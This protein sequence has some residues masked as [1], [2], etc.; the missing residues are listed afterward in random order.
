[1]SV[2]LSG[3]TFEVKT[4]KLSLSEISFQI[5]GCVFLHNI[6]FEITDENI[7]TSQKGFL[8]NNK[9]IF[10]NNKMLIKYTTWQHN[11]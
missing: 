1:M 10:K 6:T 8:L 7:I 9:L 2:N 3:I 11:L 4:S 5:Y